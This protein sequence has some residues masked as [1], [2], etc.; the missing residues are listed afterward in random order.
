MT[1]KFIDT[2]SIK[3]IK[4]RLN[5]DQFSNFCNENTSVLPNFIDLESLEKFLQFK[6]KALNLLIIHIVT[7]KTKNE[8]WVPTHFHA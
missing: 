4:I 6:I 3:S 7:C 8:N 2:V 1:K 5:F